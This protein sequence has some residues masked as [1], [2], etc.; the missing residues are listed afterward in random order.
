MWDEK[1]YRYR[2]YQQHPRLGGS[3][4]QKAVQGVWVCS[5]LASLLPNL[6]FT[7]RVEWRIHVN[8]GVFNTTPTLQRE[9]VGWFLCLD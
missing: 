6:S 3:D 8:K 1:I 5:L 9:A 4:L 7:K 2:V